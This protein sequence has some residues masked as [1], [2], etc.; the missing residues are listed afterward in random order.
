MQALNQNLSRLGQ[1]DPAIDFQIFWIVMALFKLTQAVH[2]SSGDKQTKWLPH[3][4]RM[5]IGEGLGQNIGYS[6]TSVLKALP[7]KLDI[8]ST[9]LVFSIYMHI[10]LNG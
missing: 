8:K 7:G 10:V 6:S 4:H 9:H 1:N 5:D 2:V 3:T